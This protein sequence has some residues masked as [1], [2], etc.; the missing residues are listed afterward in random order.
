[1]DALETLSEVSCHGA[2]DDGLSSRHGFVG[3]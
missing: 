3:N 1:M 2:A